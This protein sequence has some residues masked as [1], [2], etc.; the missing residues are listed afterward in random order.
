MSAREWG[1]DAGPESVR[2]AAALNAAAAGSLRAG[3]DP[4]GL[5]DALKA[6]ARDLGIER[7]TVS[8]AIAAAVI[9]C[10]DVAWI[11]AAG[12]LSTRAQEIVTILREEVR[13]AAAC[14]AGDV[15]ARRAAVLE[16]LRSWGHVTSR[17]ADISRYTVA[18]A[19]RPV[20]DRQGCLEISLHGREIAALRRAWAPLRLRDGGDRRKRTATPVGNDRRTGADRRLSAAAF[21]EENREAVVSSR[22]ELMPGLDADA[23]SRYVLVIR[24]SIALLIARARSSAQVAAEMAPQMR[25]ALRASRIVVVGADFQER[26]RLESVPVERR[27]LLPPAELAMS[28]KAAA[29]PAKDA[30]AG[31]MRGRARRERSIDRAWAY[32]RAEPSEWKTAAAIVEATGVDRSVLTRLLRAS[33]AAGWVEVAPERRASAEGAPARAMLYR[34]TASAP[35]AAPM[36]RADSDGRA[37]ADAVEG[38][39]SGAELAR[40]RIERGWSTRQAA[41]AV[42]IDR[43][44]LEKYERAARVPEA[45]AARV[46]QACGVF[47]GDMKPRREP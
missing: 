30:I 45:M 26:S 11:G 38:A 34:I 37:V 17:R 21:V 47:G 8:A 32:L 1:L 28:Q 18:M 20:V 15:A 10:A 44:T 19:S 29:A 36:V 27:M 35:V 41:E 43:R 31:F 33:R 12:R 39:M 6:R 22:D 42:G 25:R 13:F 14:Y 46:A 5:C 2:C 4:F 40:L 3:L 7:P 23:A 9:E 16:R 24:M